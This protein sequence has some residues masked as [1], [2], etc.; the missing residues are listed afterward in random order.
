MC[1][2][3]KVVLSN[4]GS[5]KGVITKETPKYVLLDL[6]TGS[7][8]LDRK[9][10]H[11]IKYSGDMERAEIKKQWQE[12]YF[13]NK[14]FVPAGHED[15]VAEFKKLLLQR[16]VALR[17]SGI[18]KASKRKEELYTK[19]LELLKDKY[20]V[21]NVKLKD[22]N[23]ESDMLRYNE[24][25]RRVNSLVAETNVKIRQIENLID[26]AGKMTLVIS[27]Y[28]L[29]LAGFEKTLHARQASLP[30]G[31]DS[32]VQF[33]YEGLSE[34]ISR[35]NDEF[36]KEV[37]ASSKS[38]RSTLVTVVINDIASGTFVLDTGAELVS[39]TEAFAARL[40]INM[41]SLPMLDITVADGRKVKGRAIV[42]KSVRLGESS[43][44]NV[45]AVILPGEKRSG[46]DG[47]LG[48]SFLSDYIVQ[49][50]GSSGN[51][52]LRQLR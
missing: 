51:L 37:I 46:H 31:S 39:M 44:K 40:G 9:Y 50:D 52:I 20:A 18:I 23:K 32:N 30:A 38:G 6:G 7:M 45:P 15:V 27:D 34:K 41:S 3:D 4:G 42:L 16:D 36:S 13:L 24:L 35:L 2:A 26:S 14:K 19:E 47:L 48:M 33:L 49:L 22:V 21:A 43:S 25:V 8:N 5:F 12:K 28:L 17:S 1:R 10:I 29:G 11:S